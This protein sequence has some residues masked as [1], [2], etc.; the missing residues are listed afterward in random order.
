MHSWRIGPAMLG[1][2]FFPALC[3]TFGFQSSI[4]VQLSYVINTIVE[5]STSISFA[6]I[7]L[8]EIYSYNESC[9]VNTIKCYDWKQNYE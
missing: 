2:F 3:L 9:L 6:L 7:L 4:I 8:F 1:S 5:A